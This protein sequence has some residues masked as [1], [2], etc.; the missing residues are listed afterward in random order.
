[1]VLLVL[2]GASCSGTTSVSWSYLQLGRYRVSYANT[3]E[4]FKEKT[5]HNC[6]MIYV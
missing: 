3:T 2:P 5:F 4:T 1:M 6:K